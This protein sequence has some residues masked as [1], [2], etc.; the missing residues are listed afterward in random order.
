MG[1]GIYSHGSYKRSG[2]FDGLELFDLLVFIFRCEGD[3]G[4]DSS[5]GN[6]AGEEVDEEVGVCQRMGGQASGAD[7]ASSD[8]ACRWGLERDYLKKI[9]MPPTEDSSEG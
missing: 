9:K 4:G 5:A 3:D 6:G 7:G 2:T 8:N 1:N